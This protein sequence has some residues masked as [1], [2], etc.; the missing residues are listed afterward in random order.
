MLW[1][2]V[3]ALIG[4]FFGTIFQYGILGIQKSVLHGIGIILTSIFFYFEL[5]EQEDKNGTKY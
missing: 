1:F 3:F 2:G 4:L 5:N